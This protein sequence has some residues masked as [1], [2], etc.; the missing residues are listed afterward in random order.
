MG[1]QPVWRKIHTKAIHPTA[2]LP[3]MKGFSAGKRMS[4]PCF[5]MLMWN[6]PKKIVKDK[7]IRNHLHLNCS[8]ENFLDRKYKKD[9]IVKDRAR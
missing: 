2:S 1:T 6:D 4:Y 8:P 9:K 3:L 5:A 7:H